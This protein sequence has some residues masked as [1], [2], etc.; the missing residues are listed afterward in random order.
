MQVPAEKPDAASGV[1]RRWHAFER[2]RGDDRVVEEIVAVIRAAPEGEAVSQGEIEMRLGELRAL[3]EEAERGELSDENWKPITLDPLLWEL[4]LSWGTPGRLGPEVLV[5]IYFGEPNLHP[6]RAVVLRV[7]EKDV[8]SDDAPTIK[9]RQDQVIR[10]A[11]LRFAEGAIPG[12][13][14]GLKWSQPIF[15]RH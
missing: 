5:R 11:S 12:A 2:N 9:R 10:E 14:W 3:V 15:S 1:K 4:R 6:D 7:H 13:E 8:S